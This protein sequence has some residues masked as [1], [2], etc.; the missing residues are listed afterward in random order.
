MPEPVPPPREWHTWKPAGHMCRCLNN[1]NSMDWSE[2]RWAAHI[3]PKA[4]HKVLCQTNH[5][6]SQMCSDGIKRNTQQ[7]AAENQ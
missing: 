3:F 7:Q 5:H 2:K 6:T 4:A 1:I